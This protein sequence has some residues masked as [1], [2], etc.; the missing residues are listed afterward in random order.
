MTAT[1]ATCFDCEY[2][3]RGLPAEATRCPECGLDLAESNRRG[4]EAE[5]FGLHARLRSAAWW[6]AAVGVAA[7]TLTGWVV[8]FLALTDF[9]FDGMQEA[10]YSVG[11]M[12]L[13]VAGL[14]CCAAASLP[15]LRG[16]VPAARAGDRVTG[17]LVSAS[18]V[19]ASV[20]T[21]AVCTLIVQDLADRIFSSVWLSAVALMTFLFGW[22]LWPAF[23]SWRTRR[24]LCS[25]PRRPL[26]RSFAALAVLM[27][28]TTVAWGLPL[29]HFLFA[30]A[31]GD[32]TAYATRPAWVDAVGALAGLLH[33]ALAVAWLASNVV[34]L[35]VLRRRQQV[36]QKGQS[37]A[38]SAQ[39]VDVE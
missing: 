8:A 19:A 27:V 29:G 23:A 30:E 20:G 35:A 14:A 17:V 25:T 28:L 15:L 32:W 37:A 10:V 3:L 7:A 22:A 4:E 33:A 6:S 24:L 39:G 36:G 34:L 5:R 38:V 12:V 18:L 13:I 9:N 1:T 2:D 16:G 31:I 11:V 26:A 21:L